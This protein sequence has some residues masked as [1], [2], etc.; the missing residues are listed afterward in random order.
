MRWLQ[1][2]A[3]TASG[4]KDRQ[5]QDFKMG[6]SGALFGMDRPSSAPLP[7]AA[8]A[9]YDSKKERGNIMRRDGLAKHSGKTVANGV[10]HAG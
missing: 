9:L 7:A 5:R 8:R 6:T 1:E 3:D 10:H 2:K 4:L